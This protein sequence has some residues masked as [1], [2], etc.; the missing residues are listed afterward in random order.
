MLIATATLS[1]V[2]AGM[3]L[4]A[5]AANASA[6]WCRPWAFVGVPG[7]N[8]GEEWSSDNPWG[9]EVKSI[10]DN[11]VLIK[12]SSKVMDFPID[13]PAKVIPTSPDNVWPYSDSLAAGLTEIKRVMNVIVDSCP[14]ARIVLAGYSQG[15]EIAARITNFS[16]WAPRARIYRTALIGDPVYNPMNV[17]TSVPVGGTR[18]QVSEPAQFY[19]SWFWGTTV[20]WDAFAQSRIKDVCIDDDIACD[21]GDALNGPSLMHPFEAH[22]QYRSRLFP[23]QSELTITQWLGKRYL[24]GEW[25]PS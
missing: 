21:T 19:F 2:A 23:G 15:A 4:V 8:Q 1:L 16:G 13:Y 20:F 17:M 14:D 18:D 6:S 3:G 11:F 7:S 25:Q 5:P 24:S 9:P 22:G 12:G 10:R